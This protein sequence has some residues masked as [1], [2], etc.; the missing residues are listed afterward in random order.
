MI[1]P[2]GPFGYRWWG[3]CSRRVDPLTARPRLESLEGRF[4]LSISQPSPATQMSSFGPSESHP[5]LAAEMANPGVPA[6]PPP[7]DMNTAAF[8]SQQYSPAGWLSPL[9]TTAGLPP[10][11][12]GHDSQGTT[13]ATF[14]PIEYRFEEQVHQTALSGADE[15]IG[16][17]MAHLE[18]AANPNPPD[19]EGYASG[20]TDTP[21]PPPPPPVQT[22]PAG[23]GVFDQ[24]YTFDRPELGYRYTVQSVPYLTSNSSST[25]TSPADRAS[26]GSLLPGVLQVKGNYQ[27][28]FDPSQANS[29]LGNDRLVLSG[30]LTD[31][32]HVDF[33]QILLPS[34]GAFLHI[35]MMQPLDQLPISN[36]LSNPS[37]PLAV[38]GSFIGEAYPGMG[39]DPSSLD[40]STNQ[41]V[42]EPPRNGTYSSSQHLVVYIYGSDHKILES[43]PIQYGVNDIN[44]NV[45]QLNGGSTTTGNTAVYLG[46][47]SISPLTTLGTTPYQLLISRTS[48]ASD[49]SVSISSWSSTSLTQSI[50]T[51]AIDPLAPAGLNSTNSAGE[52]T[53]LAAPVPDTEASDNSSSSSESTLPTNALVTTELPV[54]TAAAFGGVLNRGEAPSTSSHQISP[55]A[56][57]VVIGSEFAPQG[58]HADSVSP[59][60]LGGVPLRVTPNQAIQ[61]DFDRLRPA[62]S[63]SGGAASPVGPTTSFEI[64]TPKSPSDSQTSSTSSRS[65]VKIGLQVGLAM[66]P[67]VV[68]TRFGKTD[69]K[70]KVRTSLLNQFKNPGNK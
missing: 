45:Q 36:G 18:S 4:L 16:S 69:P 23:L 22:F 61:L 7:P 30:G 63:L 68:Y 21:P 49:T 24:G 53:D 20:L 13:S 29:F 26:S 67:V 19:W 40:I 44:L 47:S 1:K 25:S 41:T 60:D 27:E 17:L 14:S 70:T 51:N 12:S 59:H 62:E 34:H 58:Q 54:R 57:D 48:A 42:S 31:R 11:P 2:D 38:R 65:D 3:S 5:G 37:H 43:V 64:E 15:R 39:G 33:Y 50:S 10:D 8:I 52:S 35:Q 56:V 66:L 32:S 9:N 6:P 55:H 28:T 46:I